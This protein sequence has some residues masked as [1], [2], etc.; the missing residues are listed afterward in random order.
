MWPPGGPRRGFSHLWPAS[1]FPAQHLVPDPFSKTPALSTE[2]P[3]PTR[4]PPQQSAPTLSP[5]WLPSSGPRGSAPSRRRVKSKPGS[6]SKVPF[7]WFPPDPRTPPACCLR[8][9]GLFLQP[10]FE[11]HRRGPRFP[12]EQASTRAPPHT[13]GARARALRGWRRHPALGISPEPEAAPGLGGQPPAGLV[14][15]QTPGDQHL[16]RASPFPG[17]TVCLPTRSPVPRDPPSPELAP[18]ETEVG[19]EV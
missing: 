11:K 2:Q 6:S 4:S 13:P 12:L 16:P 10:P 17:Q 14:V 1:L 15:L 19:P 8:V 3:L 9:C 7:M 5:S 18:P